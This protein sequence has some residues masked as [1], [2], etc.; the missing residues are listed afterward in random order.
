MAVKR[1]VIVLMTVGLVAGPLGA[2][3]AQ[4]RQRTKVVRTVV[5]KYLPYPAPV[6]GCNAAVDGFA[7]MVVPTRPTE[8]FVAVKVTDAHGRPVYFEVLGDGIAAGF[9]GQT[10]RPVRFD[11][12]RDLEIDVGLPRWGIQTACPASSVKTTGTIRVTLTDRP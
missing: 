5:G 8:R 3:E 12:G 10:K 2:V 9:C 7:C 1:S 6:T 4:Q 11:H